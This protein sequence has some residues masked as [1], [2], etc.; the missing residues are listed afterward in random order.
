MRSQ[1]KGEFVF[2]GTEG[3]PLTASNGL[4]YLSANQL[5]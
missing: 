5:G 4:G 2:E 3:K 1:A